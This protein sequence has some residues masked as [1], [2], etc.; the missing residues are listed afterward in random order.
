MSDAIEEPVEE[1]PV[2]EVRGLIR[3]YGDLVAVNDVSFTVKRGEMF[4]LIGPDGAGKTTTIRMLLGL[5]TPTAGTAVF[6][7]RKGAL[8]RFW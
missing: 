6:V 2:V 5:V 3:K 7:N 8:R 1:A 4:G